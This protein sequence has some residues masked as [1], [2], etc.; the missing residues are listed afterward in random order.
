M[1]TPRLRP[2][3]GCLV[4]MCLLAACA[5]AETAAV[6][7][8]ALPPAPTVMPPTE[9]APLT[10]TP[11]APAQTW[12]T[13]DAGQIQFQPNATTWNTPGI[14]QPNTAIR[15]TLSAAQGQQMT[16]WLHTEPPSEDVPQAALMITGADG[17]VFTPAPS[18]YWSSVLPASQDYSIEVL[19][20]GEEE[21]QYMLQIE[22]P[23]VTID[24]ASADLY[25][26]IDPSL[27]QMLR[28]EAS[29]AL[30]VDFALQD[31]APFL[32]ALAGE[33]GQGCR[34]R[35][36]GSGS[37][38]ASPQAV[39]QALVGSA[40]QGWTEQPAYQADG[41]TGSGAALTRDMG[42]M[43]I[44]AEWKPAMGVECPAD[45]PIA[46]CN[47]TPE[48]MEYRIQIDV[49]QYRAAFS[50]DG[51]W[52]DAATGFTLDLYQ[53]W[54]NI[55]GKHLIVA[56]DGNKID[57]LDVSINGALQG[58]TATVQ[59]QSSFAAGPGT[60]EITYV[61]VNTIHWKIVAPPDGEYY[62]PAEA[63]LTRE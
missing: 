55:Y 28:E 21:I 32:D 33:A 10:P 12:Q 44:L 13:S 16:V 3:V 42:L 18:T 39:V 8:T 35:A 45:Q 23:A 7:P 46:A 31:R 40:G 60:A 43:L 59:F 52:E 2:M 50:L 25:E 6:S 9:P 63:T 1:H 57:S 58:Q 41:P 47:L 51:H 34:L 17:Q 26:P 14:L 53:D 24:L 4:L 38:F 48:Q 20:L 61:D 56:Q 19:S 49:A 22:I 29:R 30:G 37:Q 5:P 11:T 15:F 62:L 54:K 36:F 27:C